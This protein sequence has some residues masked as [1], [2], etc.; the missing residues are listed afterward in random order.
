MYLAG[1]IFIM[2]RILALVLLTGFAATA[3]AQS[4]YMPRNV[5]DAYAKG[6]RS[7]DG[8][9]GKNYWQNT[10][11]YDIRIAAAPPSREVRGVET[12]TYF[13]NSPDTLRS[14]VM[15]LTL[16]IHKPGAARDFPAQEE[17]LSTGI[18]IDSFIADGLIYNR[19]DNNDASTW[20][21]VTLRRPLAPKDSLNMY[22]RWHY[23]VSLQSNRE[24]MLDSTSFFLAYFY[25]RVAVYDDYYGWDRIDFTDQKE[26]Y[27]DFNDYTLTVTVPKNYLVWATGDL[28]NPEEVLQPAYADKY[29]QSLTA[30]DVI[31]I[32]TQQ[33]LRSRNV[34]RQNN[35]N[36]WR[37]VAKNIPDVAVG[38]S[39][40]Y[41]WDASSTVVDDAAGRRVSVQAAYVDTS[42]D[43][44]FMVGWVQKDLVWLSTKWPG[45]PYPYSKTTIFQGV[46]DMEYPMMVNDNSFGAD[47]SFARFVAAHEVAH[48]WFPFYMGINESR[49]AFMDE[50]WATAFELLLNRVNMD[51]READINF[52]RFRVNNWVT[53]KTAEQNLP[54][55]TPATI[56]KNATYGDNAYGKPALAYLALKELLGDQ[57]FKK[58]LHEFIRR[59]NG[60]HPT[61]WDF[62]YTFNNASGK[63]LNWFWNSWFF[64]TNNI[65]LS[66]KG[67]T[68]TATGNTITVVN[69]G[70]FPVPFDIQIRYTDATGETRHFSTGI[71]EK[72]IKQ[73]K[74][75]IST[76]KTIEAVMINGGV[77]QDGAEGNN[78][79]FK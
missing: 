5:Q 71:W 56:L 54:I 1:Q 29:R 64:S 72:D 46:A 52:R 25:P 50:G 66:V 20:Q 78:R 55:I 35:M 69:E 9:P 48:T 11:R 24:G 70:G 77:F 34:T 14:V 19:W 60:K 75:V 47:T 68:P 73:A 42:R 45:W 10:A 38:L 67:V 76:R 59:W 26:F 51:P 23:D 8:K 53:N 58:C 22:V 12:I 2:A 18:I 62:F 79:W 6:T 15:R 27:N 63:N 30:S 17:Y 37:F 28:Q 41:V 40:H 43:F 74:L 21:T 32:A 16:N 49:Y 7:M 3:S 4:L 65:D 33:D 13:N 57:V 39:N 31:H 44:R 61:P 36:S